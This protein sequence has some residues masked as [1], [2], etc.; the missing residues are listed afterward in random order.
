ETEE[1]IE[2]IA[3]LS[4]MIARKYYERPKEERNGKVSIVTSSSFFVPKPFTPFQWSRMDTSEEYLDK[5]KILRNKINEQLNKKSIKYNWH[6]AD[7]SELEGALARGDRRISKVIY[8]AYQ[9]GCLYDSWSEFFSFDKWLHAF[10][11]NGIDYRFYTC[12]ERDG[13]EVF[14]WDFIDVGVSK[15]FLYREYKRAKDE[16]VTL[17]CKQTCSGCGA[18]VFGGGVCFDKEG[19]RKEVSYEG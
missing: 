17:N 16:K 19:N 3:I 18:T 4:D 9:A 1:D 7:L 2:G 12:R 13:N 14:P 6:E 10:E 8:D 15:R 11:N 5:Q